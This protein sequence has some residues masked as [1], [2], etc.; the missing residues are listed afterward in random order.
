MRNNLIDASIKLIITSALIQLMHCCISFDESKI[1]L[2]HA[3]IVLFL[4]FKDVFYSTYMY[5]RL[6]YSVSFTPSFELID[7]SSIST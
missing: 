2:M 4:L 1:Y 3:L 7:I 6:N 5:T